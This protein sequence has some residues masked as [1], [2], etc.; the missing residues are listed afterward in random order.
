MITLALEFPAGESEATRRHLAA[1]EALFR[2]GASHDALVHFEHVIEH[3]TE[4]AATVRAGLRMAELLWETDAA[5]RAVEYAERARRQAEGDAAAEAEA[6]MVLSRL[7]HV[8]DLEASAA[9]AAR[10]V[11]SLETIGSSADRFVLAGSLLS[12]AAADFELGRGLDHLRFGRAIELERIDPPSR[13]ADRA[14]AAYASL[15]KMADDLDASR[16]GLIAVREAVIAE[17]DDSSMPFVLG[18]LVQVELWAGR[19]DEAEAVALDHRSH[20]ARTGQDAQ[21]RQAEYN[22]AIVAAHRGDELAAIEIAG[23]LATEA[24]ES[25]DSWAEMS[26]VNVLGF[27]ALCRGEH[28]S[29]VDHFEVGYGIAENMCLREPGR[30]RSRTDHIE[31]LIAIGDRGRAQALL[32]EYELRSLALDRASTRATAARCRALLAAAGGD[33]LA[34]GRASESSLAQFDRLGT[35]LFAFERA[36]SLLVSGRLLRRSK[37]KRAADRR[38]REAGEIFGSLGAKRFVDQT[39]AEL[40]RVGLRPRAPSEL[41]VGERVVAELVA[42]GLTTRQAAEA[43][44]MS[45]KTVEANL[46]RIYRKLGLSSRAELGAWLARQHTR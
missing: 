45:P 9:A 8:V 2:S 40:D 14:D 34:A 13:I 4:R 39:Q 11:A 23:D 6:D 15:L 46:T 1:G 26:A 7:L 5:E 38:L 3:S 17:G 28:A 16:A 27:V 32:E 41:T 20:A 36:R 21:R 35:G 29:A 12:G 22:L 24:R 30:T 10:A 25:A 31:C 19:W 37:Q 44:F 18:H 33:D 42:T 43:A